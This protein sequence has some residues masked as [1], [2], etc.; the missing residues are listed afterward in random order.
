MTQTCASVFPQIPAFPP[1]RV[2]SPT[3][4][5]PLLRG[6]PPLLLL[7]SCPPRSIIHIAMWI[8][9][10]ECI[11]G[12]PLPLS[13]SLE[14]SLYLCP[15]L[16]SPPS[17]VKSSLQ[18][19]SKPRQR[20]CIPNSPPESTLTFPLH[21]PLLASPTVS[22]S[23][24]RHQIKRWGHRGGDGT[25]SGLPGSQR[26]DEPL[27]PPRPADPLVPPGEGHTGGPNPD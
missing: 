26:E 7:C 16:T 27:T 23:W 17:P 1:A 24:W 15:F 18:T 19:T 3:L 10:T 22:L 5:L 4:F 20:I 2:G 14:T 9:S 25:L 21:T 6:D 13:L 11:P 8:N 12:D